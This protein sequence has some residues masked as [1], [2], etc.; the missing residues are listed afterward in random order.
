MCIICELRKVIEAKVKAHGVELQEGMRGY[1]EDGDIHFEIVEKYNYD[2]IVAV[3]G[4][5]N[6]YLMHKD[7]VKV[8]LI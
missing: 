5:N 8:L 2:L 7:K 1:F 4:S 6:W 3:D